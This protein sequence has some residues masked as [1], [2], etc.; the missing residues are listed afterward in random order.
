M[1]TNRRYERFN[2][3]IPARRYFSLRQY[4]DVNVTQI[5]I[6]G[7]MI[8]WHESFKIGEH[9]RLELQLVRGNWLPIQTKVLYR[10]KNSA[11]GIK[12]LNLTKFE[13]ELIADAILEKLENEGLPL[14]NPFA[15]PSHLSQEFVLP[16]EILLPTTPKSYS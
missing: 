8:E 10:F 16:S 2:I 15:V 9:F 4:V 7:G 5:S 3:I 1:Q 6:A 14:R 11:V 13:E 12:F